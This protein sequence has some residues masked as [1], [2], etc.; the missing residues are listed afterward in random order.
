MK[1]PTMLNTQIR[2][3]SMDR[4]LVLLM[5]V[6]VTFSLQISS[7]S[8]QI[9]ESGQPT[10]ASQPTEPPSAKSDDSE[11]PKEGDD[12]SEKKSEQDVALPL[13]TLGVGMAIVLGLIIVLKVNAFIA[14]ISAAMVVSL[15]APGEWASK[16][17][18]V[19]IA[20]GSTAGGIGIVIALAAVI[21]K[22]MLDSGAADRV[23]RAFLRLLGEKRAP[24]ALMGSG[25]VLAVP[26][27]F[28]T[29]FYLL[30][31]LAR[32]MHRRTG[33][34]YLTYILAIGAGGAITHT[35][36]PPTPG[37]LVMADN[38]N[39]DV[40][41]MIMIGALVAMPAAFAG[42]LVAGLMDRFM[43]TPMRQIGSEPD[44]E[45]LDDSELPSLF[46]SLLPVL[47]PVLLISTNTILT[48]VADREHAAL[49][50]R[51]DIKEWP[52]FRAQLQQDTEADGSNPAKRILAILED[53]DSSNAEERAEIAALLLQ[54]QPL[55]DEDKEKELDG[56]KH[57]I[58]ANK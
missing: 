16:I 2:K 52:Q 39:F 13:I 19:A 7:V 9:P 4:L 14:L 42:L 55:S 5:F 8:G 6:A 21:G 34:K 36:V 58:L 12:S 24:M 46:L 38:L 50:V 40:G 37:P 54:D 44:P 48:T 20:F 31:P 51:D 1:A 33:K 56:L 18:R 30:V 10:T 17:S 27:F 23:V 49:I 15:M 22:C 45:P 11:K 26:V 29:V 53:T 25:F 3:V 28:D 57:Y 32:S 35:L 47:L 43:G 41:W